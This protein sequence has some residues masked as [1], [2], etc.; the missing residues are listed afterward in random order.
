MI[1]DLKQEA[2][3][4]GEDFERLKTQLGQ[5]TECFG[6]N[7]LEFEKRKEMNL[8]KVINE[9]MQKAVN[10]MNEQMQNAVNSMM[11]QIAKMGVVILGTTGIG[12][13]PLA[14]SPLTSMDS[15]R[16]GKQK[17]MEDGE[18][19]V[20]EMSDTYQGS[21]QTTQPPLPIE[22]GGAEGGPR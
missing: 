11:L 21:F 2:E 3:S 13:Q 6:A 8:M 20:S 16:S 9:Q 5:I 14:I 10:N 1:K 4:R 17:T 15:D 12:T 7:F 22:P 19:E 18:P